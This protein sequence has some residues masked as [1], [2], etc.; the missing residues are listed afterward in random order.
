MPYDSRQVANAF[1]ELAEKSQTKVTNMQLQKL[2]FLAQG[3]SLALRDE[4]LT[5]HNIHAWQWGPV[6]PKLYKAC[7]QYGNMPIQEK[8]SVPPEA[9]FEIPPDSIDHAII[10]GVWESYGHWT[11]GQ[12][13]ALTHEAGSP[14][15]VTWKTSP[16]GI[17]D[18]GVMQD[19]YKA[20]TDA[21]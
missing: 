11:G 4:P 13:S 3:F 12:L 8:L 10:R 15:D 17:I 14:W 20:Q 19:F 2:V 21:S 7:K 1:L 6:L 16:Y 18:V 9:G 5:Y